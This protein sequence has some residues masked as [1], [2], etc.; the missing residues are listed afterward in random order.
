[1]GKR[2]WFSA[3]AESAGR[4]FGGFGDAGA[5]RGGVVEGVEG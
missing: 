1:M 5:G 2:R 3:R 4:C